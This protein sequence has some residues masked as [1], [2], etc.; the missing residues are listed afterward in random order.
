[1]QNKHILIVLKYGSFFS[2]S[3][4]IIKE[5]KLNNKVTLCIQEKNKTNS[6]NYYID[7][8]NNSLILEN[9]NSNKKVILAKESQNLKIINGVE[10]RDYW[11]KLLKIIRET[12]NYISYLIRGDKNTFFK[13]QSKYVSKKIIV[14]LNIVKLK[15]ILKSIYYFLK[16]IHS[17]IPSSNDIKKF[18]KDI[19]PDLVLVVGANWPTRNEKFSS[20]I[21]FIKASKEIRKPS[22]LQVISWDNLIA[23]GLY[24]YIP[25]AMFVWNKTHFDEAINV[26]KIPK[27]NL[28]IIGAPFMDKWFE[29]IKMPSRKD[30]LKSIGMDIDKPLVTY[31]GSAKNIST[32]EKRIVEEI[33]E[34]LSKMN[35]QLLVRPHGANT[36]QFENLNKKIKIFPAKGELPDTLEAKESM[37]ATLKHSDFSV[38]INTTAMIDSI[39]LGTPCI[40][41]VKKEFKHNQ[42]DTPHFNKVQKERIFIEAHNIKEIINKIVEFNKNKNKNIFEKMNKFVIEFCRPFGTDVSA[43]KKAAKEIEELIKNN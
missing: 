6:S 43:G 18:I 37:I 32:S 34:K 30:F 19:D 1:M 36:S 39:I 35:I 2:Y 10:R 8:K 20:E 13:N 15:I 7:A 26:Q 31:L 29:D 16:I 17:L 11:V 38:G 21:D 33:Y 24:H 5:L 14:F 22:V 27:K 12:L 25:S 4:S 3:E 28:R 42:V 9:I 40:S 41:L 23:R